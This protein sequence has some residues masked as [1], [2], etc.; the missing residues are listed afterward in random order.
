[1][2]F[3]NCHEREVVLTRPNHLSDSQLNTFFGCGQQ[4]YYRYIEGLIIPPSVA[5]LS[6][7]SVHSAADYNFSQKIESGVDEPLSVLQDVAAETYYKESEDG[8]FVSEDEKSSA[9]KI[10]NK[11]K[12]EAVKLVQPLH[13]K[14]APKI[15][16]KFVE[17]R[18]EIKIDGLPPILGFVDL[19]GTNLETGKPILADIKTAKTKW[20]QSKAD[21]ATQPALYQ[22]MTTAHGWETPDEFTF[23]VLVKSKEPYH[24]TVTTTRTP[25]DFWALIKRFRIMDDQ[26]KHGNFLPAEPGHWRCSPKWCGYW[27]KCPYIPEHKKR[28]PK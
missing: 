22:A 26:I 17:K 24:E 6:G 9:E 10:Y 1:V 16:P 19:Y 20:S 8:F 27:W 25:D 7:K 12:D 21:I 3:G 18:F 15:Q 5:L 28:I 11:G 23:E 13:E 14:V 2:T 4:Y